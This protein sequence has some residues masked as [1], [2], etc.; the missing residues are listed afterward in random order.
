M[1]P[2]DGPVSLAFGVED[3]YLQILAG[4][5]PLQLLSRVHWG[6]LGTVLGLELLNAPARL[7]P[8]AAGGC[9]SLLVACSHV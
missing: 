8:G 9:L 4:C 3:S 6:G 1:Q 7:C 5:K 2:E